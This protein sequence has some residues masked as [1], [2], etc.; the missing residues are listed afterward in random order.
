MNKTLI[1]LVT[2]V[3]I[4][5]FALTSVAIAQQKAAPAQE[6]TEAFDGKKFFDELSSRGW[7]SPA[8]FDGKKF[9]EDLSSRGWSSTNKFDG[10]KFFEELSSRGWSS[11]VSFDGK[12]FWEEQT[13]R[14]GYNMPPMVDGTK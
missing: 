8:S 14:G 5:T 6:K 3:A 4:G 11:P 13:R 1:K 2:A 7:K 9:F 12:K 10:K